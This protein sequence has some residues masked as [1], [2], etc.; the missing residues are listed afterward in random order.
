MDPPC[1]IKLQSSIKV[2]NSNISNVTGEINHKDDQSRGRGG[3]RHITFIYM[4]MHPIDPH[5]LT[6]LVNPIVYLIRLQRFCINSNCK[7]NC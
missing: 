5:V 3:Q 7:V 6:S 4:R 2:Y 1:S